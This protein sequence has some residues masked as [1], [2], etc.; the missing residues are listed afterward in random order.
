MDIGE[1]QTERHERPVKKPRD[2]SAF[3]IPST[4]SSRKPGAGLGP[5]PMIDPMQD[6]TTLVSEPRGGTQL[7]Q[8]IPTA[9]GP[10]PALPR[11]D[12]KPR[13]TI[14]PYAVAGGVV[15]LAWGGAVAAGV[16]LD[17]P[18]LPDLETAATA[19]PQKVSASTPAPAASPEAAP[20]KDEPTPREAPAE[21]EPEP[22]PDPNAGLTTWSVSADAK[23]T[24]LRVAEGAAVGL[25]EGTLRGYASGAEAWTVEGAFVDAV[26]AADGT[27]VTVLDGKLKGYAASTGEPTFDVALPKAK[28]SKKTPSA[29][30]M[31]ADASGVLVALADARFLSVDPAACASESDGCMREIG[32]LRG[33]YLEGSASVALGEEGVR[34]LGEED[35][36]RAFDLDF[37]TTFSLSAS[38]DI[39]AIVRVPG[40]RVALQFGQETALLDTASCRGR[41]EVQ[42]LPGRATKAPRGCVLW[43]YGRKIEPAAPAAVDTASL[44]MNEDGKLQVVAEGDDTWKS[45][46]NTLGPV[47][48]GDGVLYTLARQ[49]EGLAL[50]AV[51]AGK[52]TVAWT[53]PLPIT[54]TADDEAAV[55]LQWRA[56]WVAASVGPHIALAQLPAG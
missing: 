15:V 35:T 39:R 49:N 9:P 41:A 21:P 1:V 7:A 4:K 43:R 50:L 6:E 18:Q 46:L 22:E 33:E 52:G 17:P 48:H 8:P 12:R 53:R 14:V 29:V 32:V 16:A 24:A 55:G 47:V 31:D 27:I 51:D 34:Y 38:A 10:T 3:D 36:M 56:G 30:A 54:A 20:T 5:V 11:S 25:F 2:I 26:S 45:P 19:V 13:K 23:P 40:N 44:A 28:R 42:L 37:R